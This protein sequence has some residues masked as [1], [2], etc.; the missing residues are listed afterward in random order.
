[1]LKNEKALVWE[2][3]KE[4]GGNEGKKGEW[5]GEPV[6]DTTPS[7]KKKRKNDFVWW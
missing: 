3:E 1:L 4:R 5:T 7:N 2:G 6:E